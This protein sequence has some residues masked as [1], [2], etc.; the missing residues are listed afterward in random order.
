VPVF[1]NKK[2]P[3]NYRILFRREF[4]KIR[5]YLLASK[6]PQGR[7]CV[8]VKSRPPFGADDKK[9]RRGKTV[10]PFANTN[11]D[12]KLLKDGFTINLESNG[13]YTLFSYE[14]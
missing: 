6:R 11:T 4:A 13:W 12:R 5:R 14:L 8:P 2:T 9:L 1:G 10:I 3:P 7:P